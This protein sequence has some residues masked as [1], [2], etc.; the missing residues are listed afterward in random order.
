MSAEELAVTW[1]GHATA[2]V[3]IG[4]RRI[5]TD[6]V[7]SSRLLHLRR[8]ADQPVERAAEADLVLV[9]HL[10]HDHC[11]RPSLRRVSPGATVLLPRG[12]ERL[13]R[14][15]ADVRPVQP[16]DRLDVAGVRVTVLPAHHDG[17]RLP[18]SHYRGPALGFRVEDGEHSFWFPGDTGS[19]VDF[20]A[21]GAVDLALV[22]IGGWGHSLGDEHLDPV[23][24]AEAVTRVGARWAVPVHWG[25]F[26]PR[27]LRHVARRTH[28]HFFVTPGER[29]A[30]AMAGRDAEA[31]VL[32]HGERMVLTFGPRRSPG[33]GE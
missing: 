22:P 30:E 25:T 1:W 8:Y 2:T 33:S 9:S 19:Q 31:L 7:L 20:D 24:A 29:F 21:V 5:V 26:F 14:D 32:A 3:E 13:L 27:G 17:R 12:G 28:Q 18:G 15:R 10:H 6:P 16:G 4:G 11:H 23:E